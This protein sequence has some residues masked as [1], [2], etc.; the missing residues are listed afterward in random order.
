MPR[1]ASRLTLEVEDVRVERVQE[2]SEADAKAEGTDIRLDDNHADAKAAVIGALDLKY[3]E[4]RR[5]VR[6]FAKLWNSINA[7]PQLCSGRGAHALLDAPHYVSYPWEDI[8]ETREYRGLPWI[9]QGNPRVWAV[10][11]RR[12]SR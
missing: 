11:F 3:V 2:I 7:K 5:P 12:I 1:W 10:T 6:A 8:R 9:V 4:L